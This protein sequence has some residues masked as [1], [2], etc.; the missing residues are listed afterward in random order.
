M[1]SLVVGSTSQLAR[2]LPRDFVHISSRDIDTAALRRDEW[3]DAYICFAEQRTYLA[4]DPSDDVRRMFHHTNVEKTLE[5]IDALHPV[6]RKILY[7]S[8]AELWNARSGPVHPSDGYAFHRNHYTESKERISLILRD[9]S[10]YPKVSVA[11]PFNF[12]SV[13]RGGHT[14][15]LSPIR[16]GYGQNGDKRPN[17]SPIT[18][19]IPQVPL[20]LPQAR[21]SF[22][23]G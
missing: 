23:R 18:V 14:E 3:D 4:S 2:Y 11:Y 10:R 12:N 6:C 22:F 5:V 15:A 1:P 20:P 9:K 7:F 21:S 8:T 17:Q 19:D 13:H 16:D